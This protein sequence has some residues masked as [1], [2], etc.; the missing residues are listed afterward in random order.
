M[1]EA[2][3]SQRRFGIYKRIHSCFPLPVFENLVPVPF[4]AS[5]SGAA[6]GTTWRWVLIGYAC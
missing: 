3:I 4:S 1:Y 2:K 5:A 6:N